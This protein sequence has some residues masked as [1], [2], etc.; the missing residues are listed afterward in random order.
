MWLWCCIDLLHVL[1]KQRSQNPRLICLKI[2][3]MLKKDW[4]CNVIWIILLP[5]MRYLSL[6]ENSSRIMR[7]NISCVFVWGPWGNSRGGQLRVR[8]VRCYYS[9]TSEILFFLIHVYTHQWKGSRMKKGKANKE[10]KIKT[11]GRLNMQHRRLLAGK[12]FIIFIFNLL[13]VK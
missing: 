9:H 1:N 12:T 10:N 5:I 13:H 2:I 3:G 11:V 4:V 6:E 8:K 7:Q